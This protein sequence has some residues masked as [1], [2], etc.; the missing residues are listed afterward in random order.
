MR[1]H[2]SEQMKESMA[3]LFKWQTAGLIKPRVSHCFSIQQFQE[4][5]ETVL[6]RTAFGRVALGFEEEATRLIIA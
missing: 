1:E 4:A 6:S 2:F 3:E 5:M